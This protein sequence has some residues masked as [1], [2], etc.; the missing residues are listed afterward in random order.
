M[1][2]RSIRGRRVAFAL[3]GITVALV[4][5][6][7][8]VP[9]DF[10]SLDYRNVGSVRVLD[11]NGIVLRTT[12]G[13][14][15]TRAVWTPL[16]RISPR[17]IEATLVA[18]DKRFFH[19]LGV[20]PLATLRAAWSNLRARRIVSGGST[21][22]QQLSG[23]LWPEPRTF[24][25]KVREAVRAVRLEMALSKD[26]ILEQYLNR[27]PY[28]PMIQGV[29]WASQVLWHVTP[30]R[31][32][33]AQA[34]TLAALPRQPGRLASPAGRTALLSARNTILTRLERVG[35]LYPDA[36]VL[37]KALPLDLEMPRAAHEAP[38]FADW[39]LGSLPPRFRHA[40]T[41][42]TTLDVRLQ[43]DV[44][45]I[46]RAAEARQN[47]PSTQAAV[48]VLSISRGDILAMVGSLDWT[49]P[50]QGQVNAALARRQ[51]GSA[52]KPFLYAMAFDDGLSAADAIADVPMHVIDAEGA[53]LS[54]RNFDG[55]YRGPVR[56]RVALASSF[57]VPAVRVQQRIGT[58]RALDRLRNAGLG[59]LRQGA[60][61]YGLGLT[62][63]VGEVTLLDLTAAYAGLARGGTWHPPVFLTGVEDA[64]RR[65]LMSRG[66]TSSRSWCTA[67]AA[68]LV[69]DI[70]A[71]D[72]A[73]IAGFGR[74]SVLDLPFPVVVK[75]GTSTGYRDAWCVGFDSD[76]V[77]GVWTGHFDGSSAEGARAA[78][79]IFREIALRLH[80]L[81]SRPWK[82]EPPAGWNLEE[83]CALS[84]MRPEPACS[85]T[86]MEWFGEREWSRRPSCP[87]HAVLDGRSV[88]LWPSA[89]RE[90][91]E[92]METT[93]LAQGEATP[94]ITSPVEGS[95]YFVDPRLGEDSSIRVHALGT[96][97]GARWFLD[98]A[99]LPHAGDGFDLQPIP[100]EHVIEVLDE[101]GQDRVRFSVR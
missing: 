91:A 44:E 40:A 50:A 8:S 92:A 83:V 32:G 2:D 95:V 9:T 39:V 98:G 20:D 52:L 66:E 78:A 67:Q 81:G 60:D 45:A 76:H 86:V 38:H 49:D 22:T 23:L 82:A 42:T 43:R 7:A 35:K 80:A 13:R 25:G 65:S 96:A 31:L 97:R 94:R 28:A 93:A 73:R 70:L 72:T 51:P 30:E 79:P 58:E 63:G 89:Y 10:E 62:L 34:A 85:G 68:F 19:H 26:E 54:P 75:T 16:E 3:F 37:A 17:L 84:G 69:Q 53:D 41:F 6:A 87:F 11:R 33:A 61:V 4:L 27:A 5:W 99:H 71:D 15:G 29:G 1:T 12:L 56:A 90:W 48:V 46:V 36:A 18:E 59:D 57:N 14:E 21:L 101:R 64:R 74:G 55:R 100:G 88:V 24:T 47:G 77:I